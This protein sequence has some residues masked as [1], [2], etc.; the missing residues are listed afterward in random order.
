MGIP[1]SQNDDCTSHRFAGSGIDVPFFERLQRLGG[2][3]EIVILGGRRIGDTHEF[4]SESQFERTVFSSGA[5][6]L[7]SAGNSKGG[8]RV[9]QRGVYAGSIFK[10]KIH[11]PMRIVLLTIEPRA[12]P[13]VIVPGKLA[14]TR[15]AAPRRRQGAACH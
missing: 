12:D 10:K 5:S 14:K 9:V 8:A 13:G 3:H 11:T 15:S 4:P 6:G 7:E 1:P 2:D